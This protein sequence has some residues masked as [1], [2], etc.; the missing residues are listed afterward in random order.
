MSDLIAINTFAGG[1]GSC[2]GYF[3]ATGRYIDVAVNH[4]PV[5]VEVHASNNPGTEHYVQNIFSVSPQAVA[6]G[7]RVGHFW[8]SPDC[9]FHSVARGAAPIRDVRRRDLPFVISG[10]WLPAL[11]P[12]VFLMENVKEILDW[13]PLDAGGRIVEAAKGDYWRSFVRQIRRL[14]YKVEWRVLRA[15]DYGV[16]T[17]RTRLYLAARRDGRPIVWPEPTHGAPD[18]PEVL[19]GERLPWRTAA[20]FIDWGLPCPSIFDSA[21]E[22]KAQYGLTAIRPLAENSLRRIARGMRRFVLDNPSPFVVHYFGDKGR[23]V[24][25]GAGL[26]EPLSV[27]TAGGNRHGLVKPVLAPFTWNITHSA[28]DNTSVSVNEPLRTVLTKSEHALAVA[29]LVREFGCSTGSSC[30]MPAPTV[31]PTGQGKTRLAVS[32]LAKLRGDNTGFLPGQPLPTL[33]TSGKHFAAVYAFLQKYNG[34]SLGQMPDEPMH[35]VRCRDGFG[36]VLCRVRGVPY[37]VADIGMRMLQPYEQAGCMGFPPWYRFD[38]A[39]G[40]P[41]TK[42]DQNRL[43]GNAVCPDMARL[44]FEANPIYDTGAAWEL[45]RE[46]QPTFWPSREEEMGVA[47]V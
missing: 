17:T 27:V 10:K 7:C 9:T 16:A 23:E 20:E 38:V 15:C 6:K 5:A 36:L 26:G 43:I 14:G 37:I 8:S 35:T 44:L 32:W 31:M 46:W 45:P 39:F 47:Y 1:G 25:R 33:T 34:K 21:A 19:A 29:H 40:K 2:L 18:S 41:V 3:L 28:N 24:F 11:R 13:G 12:L 22:I 4:D 30:G 42:E